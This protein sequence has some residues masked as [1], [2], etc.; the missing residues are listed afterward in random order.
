MKKT[1]ETRKRLSILNFA[2]FR[3]FHP[4]LAA[5]NL[6]KNS[7]FAGWRIRTGVLT[8]PP[9][10][11]AGKNPRE[12]RSI[13]IAR[14]FDTESRIEDVAAQLKARAAE[15][16]IVAL[17]AFLGVSARRGAEKRLAELSGKLV[18]EVPTLPPSILGMRLDD[19]L[20]SRFAA[21]GGVFIAGDRVTGGRMEGGRLLS[22]NTRHGGGAELS[23]RFFVLATG[24]FFSGGLSSRVDEVSEPVLGLAVDRTLPRST[25]YAP[26]FLDP[27]SH[28]F[29]S[30]GVSTNETLNPAD[31]SGREVKN[32]FCAGAVLS[33]YNPV[34]EGSG[35]G[36]A[37]ATGYFAAGRIMALS[38]QPLS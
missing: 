13:D 31:A 25:W 14:I 9:A 24:S 35:S 36:V 2:G 16:D 28:P 10:A 1:F 34:R 19:A 6:R 4:A 33:G 18:Y 23:A 11:P 3:D 7:L 22:V 32:L 21:E 20:K 37:I 27:A 38:R 26:R 30:F 29:L 15:A 5:V 8:L 12:L 17:P